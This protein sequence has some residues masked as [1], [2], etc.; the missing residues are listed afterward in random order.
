MKIIATQGSDHF[1]CVVSKDEIAN[2]IG[3]YSKYDRDFPAV[4]EG[5]VIDINGMYRL[6][7]N[8]AS[9]HDKLK[10]ANEALRTCANLVDHIAIDKLI[11]NTEEV[12][13]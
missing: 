7:A 11:I 8:M 3:Y 9:I 5:S 6:A 2:L 13:S 12:K 4:K 1:L 10:G